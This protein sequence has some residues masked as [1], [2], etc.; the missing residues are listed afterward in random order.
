[1]SGLDVSNDTTRFEVEAELDDH[2]RLTQECAERISALVDEHG[3]AVMLGLLTE[4]ECDAGLNLVREVLDDPDREKAT[5]ASQ[6]DIRYGRRDFC[7]LPSTG[8]LLDYFALLADRAAP[9]LV[10][11][12]GLTRSVLEMSTLTSYLG[13]SHQYLHRD[14]SGVLCMFAALDDVSDE[15]GGTVFVPG[16]HRYNG[17]GRRHGG[18]SETLMQIFQFLSNRRVYPY[19]RQ[20]LK[21]MV[22]SG[23]V[24]EQE[25]KDKTFSKAD[26]IHQPNLRRLLSN[27]FVGRSHYTLKKLYRRLRQGQLAQETFELVQAAPPKGSVLIYRSDMLHAGPD[28]RSE[29]PRYFLNINIARD[30]IHPK[31]WR[32][33][34]SAHS[35]LL[36]DPMSL[37]DLIARSSQKRSTG[38]SAPPREQSRLTHSGR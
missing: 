15:Q 6:T 9:A 24:S 32:A 17:S 1:M 18:R 7:P 14:P 27:P 8:P 13:S 36:D 34:Y 25:Y 11:H 5:F 3:F 23:E 16:T 19:N 29:K 35:S 2:G 38:S 20:K 10:L 30:S 22:R 28:N 4:E 12:C 37:G 31:L 21:G 26:D 33:G